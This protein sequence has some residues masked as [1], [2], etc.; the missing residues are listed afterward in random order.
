M[1]E[2]YSWKTE[3][4]NKKRPASGILMLMRENGK[5]R[6]GLFALLT[7]AMLLCYPVMTALTLSRYG[8]E[9][10]S[11]VRW[12]GIGHDMLG[13]S[14]GPAL[15]LVTIGA[16]LCAV[17]GFS[18]IYS[19]KKTD[20]YLSQPVTAGQR[21][22]MIYSNGILLYFVPYLIS[23]FLTLLVIAGAGAASAALFVNVLFTVPVS[24]VYFLTVY[25]VTLIAMMISGKRGMAGFFI[26]AGFLYEVILRST[27]V[28]YATTYF[29]T[30]MSRYP[31]KRFITPV[32]RIVETIDES[33]FSWGAGRVTPGDV[34][35]HLVR[36]MLPGVFILLLEAVLFGAIAYYCY[37]KRPVEAISQAVA[38][39]VLK[40]PV[41]V[42][43]ML[44]AGLLGCMFFCNVSGY[45]GYFVAIPGV[46][47]G[48][49]FCQALVEIV[50]ESDLK[51]FA[52]HKRSFAAGAVLTLFVYL[53]FALDISGYDN[54]VP[55]QKQV[56][57][58]AIE[59]TFE[60][61]YNFQYVT[62]YDTVG[63]NGLFRENYGLES[64]ELTDVSG[65]LSL[66]RDGMGKDAREQNPD[67]QLNCTVKYK[68]NNGKE[69]YREFF[70][71][72]EQ[73][74]TVLDILF[75]NQEYKEGTNQVLEPRMDRI[76]EKSRA[77]Y[78]NGLQETE[79]LD[80]NA[81]TL[82][83]AYQED[84]REMSFSDVKEVVPCGILELRYRSEEGEENEL[85]YPVF[86]S[87]TRTIEYLR[88]KNIELYLSINPKAVDSIRLNYY[89]DK[90]DPEVIEQKSFFGTTVGS[91]QT[92][93]METKEYDRREQIEELLGCLYPSSLVN[94]CYT[95]D[96][97]EEDI[98][99]SIQSSDSQEAYLYHWYDIS[100]RVRE[101]ELPEFV[102]EDIGLH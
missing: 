39:P 83:R 76:F 99:V 21:F 14:G 82:M 101:T 26:L 8:R 28:S 85:E 32:F 16:V 73:E 98:W 46:I 58:A 97:F 10:V 12:Q 40:G 81:L 59:I 2:N 24:F 36:P 70:I 94:W 100:F 56:E 25:H 27:L 75:A 57:S 60:N 93:I 67:T 102:K 54:W 18:W 7:F 34:I 78:D 87:F 35:E 69:K 88:G 49:L 37:K 63:W 9:E 44:P 68:L 3:K 45:D 51:A 33:S 52:R 95:S 91:T 20:M 53:F 17:E 4:Q 30:Y 92:S 41:K 38:F 55:D 84:L 64:M 74:K 5:R 11:L 13:I 48:I 62:E 79:I 19:R 43:L 29:S 50:Y 90:E 66:A 1:S 31:M 22:L 72:Y 80:K 42:L 6:L 86:P 89:R 15:F 65:V 77:Y 61:H 23:L 71:D 96:S 47:L